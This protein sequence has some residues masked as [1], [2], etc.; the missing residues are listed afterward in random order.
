M[1]R[2]KLLLVVA[3]IIAAL[4]TGLVY[5]YVQ[6]A[7]SR[8]K[9]NVA[10]VEVVTATAV[11]S[12]GETIDQIRAAGKLATSPVPRDQLLE[13]SMTDTSQ[14]TGKSANTT[15]YPGEQI[16]LAKF[17]EG[18]VAAPTS[19]DIPDGMVAMSV[20]LD[21]PARVAGFVNPGSEIALYAS[22]SAGTGENSGSPDQPWVRL[23]LP[24]VTVIGVGSTTAVSTTTTDQTGTATTEQMPRT[25]MTLAVD[26]QD[27]ERVSLAYKNSELWFA[28]RTDK[29]KIDPAPFRTFADLWKK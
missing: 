1:D 22:G 19:L 24:K 17:T 8:A 21:D 15:I 4:G 10:S 11:I 18:T 28:L 20:Q 9:E 5:L 16:V 25:L 12:P 7:D 6:S 29:S 23:V 26:Q 13:G 2:R 27:A 3:A 14:L